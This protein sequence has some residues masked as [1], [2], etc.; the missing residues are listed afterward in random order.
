MASRVYFRI[1]SG[2]DT[3][4]PVA[5]SL[6]LLKPD[7]QVGARIDIDSQQPYTYAMTQKERDPSRV[8]S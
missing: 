5:D 1:R 4:G 6:L 2:S 7:A 8:P 3:R